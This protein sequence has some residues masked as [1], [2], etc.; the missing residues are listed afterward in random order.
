M[1]ASTG[2]RGLA[3]RFVDAGQKLQGKRQK[4]FTWIQLERIGRKLESPL[5]KANAV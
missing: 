1:E 2:R 5:L 4:W 3:A